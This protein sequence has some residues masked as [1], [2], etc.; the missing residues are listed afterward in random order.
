MG[1]LLQTTA[2]ATMIVIPHAEHLEL[3]LRSKR[4][5]DK[6]R[7][8]C[9][10]TM[11]GEPLHVSTIISIDKVHSYHVCIHTQDDDVRTLALSCAGSLFKGV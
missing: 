10:Q 2:T 4:R 9:N 5:Q 3:E 8:D 1:E 11:L 7:H 6:Q